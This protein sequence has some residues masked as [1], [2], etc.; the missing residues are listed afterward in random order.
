MTSD[1]HAR[2]RTVLVTGVGRR[3]GI[4]FAITRRLL[5][6]ESTRVFAHSCDGYDITE[7]WGAGTPGAQDTLYC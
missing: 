1:A 7:P 3:E 4:G 2:G 5:R 6:D